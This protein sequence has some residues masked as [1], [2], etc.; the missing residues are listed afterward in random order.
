MVEWVDQHGGVAGKVDIDGGQ[1]GV[2]AGHLGRIRAPRDLRDE[3]GGVF[4]GVGLAGRH[5]TEV[6]R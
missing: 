1:P 3:C 2:D 6:E 4:A 5:N